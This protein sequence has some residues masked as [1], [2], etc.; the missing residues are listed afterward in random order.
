MIVKCNKICW[1]S[2]KGIK[3]HVGDQDDI[4]PLSPIASYF[5]FPEGTEVYYKTKGKSPDKEGKGGTPNI[6]TTRIVG[7][8]YPTE[9]KPKVEAKNDDAPKVAETCDVCNVYQG[10][11]TQV[12]VHKR[13]CLKKQ[14]E[15]EEAEQVP[16]EVKE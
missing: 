12:A 8:P 4:D 13:H 7:Q 2:E 5:D 15:K 6:E 1:N 9:A 11:H 3:Y 10:T 14:S 16:E